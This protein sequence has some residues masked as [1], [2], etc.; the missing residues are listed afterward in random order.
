M[1]DKI[2]GSLIKQRF[3]NYDTEYSAIP[4]FFLMQTFNIT[5]LTPEEVDALSSDLP[6]IDKIPIHNITKMLKNIN[7]NYPF[8]FPTYGYVLLACGGTTLIILIIG[9]L[10]YV[11]FRRDR[12]KVP[13]RK[14]PQPISTNDIELQPMPVRTMSKQAQDLL[15]EDTIQPMKVTPLILKTKLEEDLGIDFSS[16]EKFKQKQRRPR[17]HPDQLGEIVQKACWT[18][19]LDFTTAPG[20]MKRIVHI[21]LSNIKLYI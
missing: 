14:R 11:K 19:F 7:K 17:K 3:F 8:V 15:V 4:N 9:I 21:L 16:Y 20:L 5:K 12:V 18:C 2:N 6:E 1:T 10:Y 13:R